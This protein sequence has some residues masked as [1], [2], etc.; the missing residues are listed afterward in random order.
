MNTFDEILIKF[1]LTLNCYNFIVSSALFIR[2]IVDL[3]NHMMLI[4]YIVNLH[5][6]GM[7]VFFNTCTVF[8]LN[9]LCFIV[10]NN[11]LIYHSYFIQDIQ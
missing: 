6:I 10:V 5:E 3:F 9:A 1:I 11:V 2:T 8:F 7:V 4:S